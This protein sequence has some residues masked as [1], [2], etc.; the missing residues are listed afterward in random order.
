MQNLTKDTETQVNKVCIMGMLR[1]ADIKITRQRVYLAGILFNLSQGHFT[2]EELHDE[3][4]Q[5]DL[6]VSL[7]TV[8]NTLNSL[9][10]IGMLKAIKTSGDKIFFDTNLKEHF[11]FYCENTGKLTDINPNSVKISKIPELPSGKKLC[12]VDVVINITNKT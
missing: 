5:G 10:D 2:A 8:Y 12:S 9:T 11:H 1:K 7:A 4:K 3:T 6:K